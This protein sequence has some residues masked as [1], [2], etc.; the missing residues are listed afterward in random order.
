M[1]ILNFKGIDVGILICH[2]VVF[3]LYFVRHTEFP[4]LQSC[5][6]ISFDAYLLSRH[7]LR[8]V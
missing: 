1:Q 6:C 5:S 4:K 7:S 8:G 3:E 2:S